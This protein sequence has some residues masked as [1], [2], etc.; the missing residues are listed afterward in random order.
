MNFKLRPWKF[1][2]KF[3]LQKYANNPKIASKMTD[4]FPHPY[5]LEDAEKFITFATEMNPI[6]IF[7]ITIE[8]EAVGGIGIHLESDI[9]RLNAELG[10]WLAENYWGKGIVSKAIQEIVAYGFEN[11]EIT[12]IYA[13]PFGSN[14]ASQ[15]VLE[16]AGF[17]FETKFEKTLIKNGV[18]EDEYY[19]SICKSKKK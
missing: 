6:S 12:R 11:F 17:Q 3:A 1:E 10:Y 15:K 5:N 16:K 8:D 7:A 9:H 19:F 18:L 14:V 2:D 13:R 4:G